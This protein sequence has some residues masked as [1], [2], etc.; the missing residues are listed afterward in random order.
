VLDSLDAEGIA[1]DTLV[2][3]TSDN[4]FYLGEHGWYDKRFMYEP[5]LRIPLVIRYPR[6]GKAGSVVEDMALNVD[7]APTILDLAGVSV[8]RAMHGQSLR[9]F[10]E[11]AQ[12]EDWRKSM[13]YA[14]YENSWKLAGFR[15]EDLSDP[16]F[17]FFTAHRV[18]PHH[19]IR[20]GRWKLIEYYSEGDYWE[21]FDLKSDPNE[22]VNLA[23]RLEH[24][25]VRRELTAE[26][27]KMQRVYGDAP[28]G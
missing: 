11:G 5:S 4:G 2:I 8:P 26:L 27:R 18:S 16:S 1:E 23:G 15:Q 7:Y 13:Y 3:Y 25:E 20:T 28:E 19:G 10:L 24:A 22:L 9:P 6:L 12:P 14:Y 21:L 17:Q